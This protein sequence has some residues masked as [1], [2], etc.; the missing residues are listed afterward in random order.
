[1]YMHTLIEPQAFIA[2]LRNLRAVKTGC[3]VGIM[4]LV[5][6]SLEKTKRERE[7]ES[8]CVGGGGGMPDFRGSADF[9]V[10]KKIFLGHSC[11][12]SRSSEKIFFIQGRGG[13]GV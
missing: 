3:G 10:F 8:V 9:R 11:D 1:M 2:K 12:S 13:G 6:R 5:G 7:R 4:V